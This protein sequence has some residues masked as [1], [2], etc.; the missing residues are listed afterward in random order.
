MQAIQSIGE[1]LQTRKIYNFLIISQHNINALK[2]L[3][4]EKSSIEAFL[5]SREILKHS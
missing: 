3:L 1:T 5:H 2:S 4:V